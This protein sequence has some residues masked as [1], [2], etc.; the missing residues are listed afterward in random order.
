MKRIMLIS[1]T[2]ILALIISIGCSPT[3]EAPEPAPGKDEE[4]EY[5][6]GTYTAVG[7]TDDKGW[8]PQVEIVVVNGKITE[9]KYDEKSEDSSIFKTQDE[10]YKENFKSINNVD[11]VSVYGKFGKELVEKQK[12]S[13]VDATGGAT[14][15]GKNFIELSKKALEQAK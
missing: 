12:P 9:A 7:E 2:L 11:I 8:T 5:K 10:E 15:S 1:L 6:D 14:Q 4:V 3:S 13:E